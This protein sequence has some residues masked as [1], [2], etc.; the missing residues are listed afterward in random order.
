MADR[1]TNELAWSEASGTPTALVVLDLN[2]FKEVNDALGHEIGDQLLIAIGDRLAEAAP[3]RATVARLGGDEF[4][5]LLPGTTLAE[6]EIEAQRL[7]DVAREQVDLDGL[8][9]SIRASMGVAAA[10]DHGYGAADLL[11]LA[12]VAMYASKRTGDDVTCYHADVDP[13]SKRRVRM[14]GELE[15]AMASG[16]FEVYYQPI[17]DLVTKRTVS[18]EGLVRWRHPELGLISPVEFI[19][20]AEVT[21]TIGRLTRL[22]V[23][24]VLQDAQIMQRAGF[25]I[26]VS[27]NLS[28]RNLFEHD[29]VD[30]VGELIK[31]HGLPAGGL[32][33]EITEGDVMED[34]VK[35]KAVMRGLAALGASLAIDDFGTGYSSLERLRDLPVSCVKIDQSFV[36]SL[37]DGPRSHTL[38]RDIITMLE[39]LGFTTVAEG[40]ED[41]TNRDQL[42]EFGCTY[43]QGYLWSRPLPM[44]EFLGYLTSEQAALESGYE[45]ATDAVGSPTPLEAPHLATP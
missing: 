11:R 33:L 6:G 1:L 8:T 4:A 43:G 7:A 45:P 19:E 23:S 21:G 20:L 16:Q 3:P 2:E 14:L 35:A 31:A 27:C 39:N 26:Q 41:V 10:P 36:H 5:I 25:P 40:I 18:T 9:L 37:M 22:V 15:S 12:D 30:S 29:F 13:F 24:R 38:L 32:R 34:P 28:T 44:A 42:S 17:V